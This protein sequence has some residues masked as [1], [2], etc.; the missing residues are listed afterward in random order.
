[1]ESAV[2]LV[3]TCSEV[4]FRAT[5]DATCAAAQSLQT[6][7]PQPRHPSASHNANAA[8]TAL[9]DNGGDDDDKAKGGGR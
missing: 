9:D 3:G 7:Y 4:C 8:A 6:A 5:W 1:M 2:A